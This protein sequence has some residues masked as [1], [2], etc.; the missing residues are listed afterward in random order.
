MMAHN[1]CYS[2]L[3]MDTHK[4]GNIPGI[5]YEQFGDHRFAQNV[6][7]VLPA[8]LNDLKA[9]RKQ[10]KKDMANA[11]SSAMKEVYNGKQLAYKISMNSMYGFTGA[12]KGILPCMAIASTTTRKG[13]SMIEETKNYVEANFPGAKV[14][15][16]GTR[17]HNHYRST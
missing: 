9:F 3:V 2:T 6:P 5:E 4:Y 1:L 16:G 7:S 15:Y 12:S 13:R 10:A 17:Y 14:R 11:T 8:I